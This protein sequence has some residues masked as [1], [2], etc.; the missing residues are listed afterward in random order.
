MTIAALPASAAMAALRPFSLASGHCG[1]LD[2]WVGSLD[3][4]AKSDVAVVLGGV[5]LMG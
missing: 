3:G 1:H 2:C 4:A 5:C